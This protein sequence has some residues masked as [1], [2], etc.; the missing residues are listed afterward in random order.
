MKKNHFSMIDFPHFCVLYSMDTSVFLQKLSILRPSLERLARTKFG[1]QEDVEDLM[2]EVSLRLCVN[3]ED[4][5]NNQDIQPIAITILKN[6]VINLRRNIPTESLDEYLDV[7]H[8]NTPHHL[9]ETKDEA[10]FILKLMGHLPPLQ[11]LILRLKDSEGY[12]VAEIAQIANT[13]PNSIYN[14][15][16]RARQK[17]KSMT[18]YESIN[19]KVL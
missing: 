6:Y 16:S 13:T 10:A 3:H 12:E 15:L 5:D 2:Q 9:V 17:I 19:R 18:H 14:N 7:P 8:F 4:W 11:Q 1:L